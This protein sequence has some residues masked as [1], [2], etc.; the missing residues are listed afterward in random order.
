[1]AGIILNNFGGNL[2]KK[3]IRFGIYGFAAIILVCLYVEFRIYRF[4]WRSKPVK[5]DSI[6]VLGCRVRGTTP[7]R[8]LIA[9]LE[10][11]LR[12]YN[13]GYGKYII[14][15]G[16]QGPGEDISEAEAMRRYLVEEG[17][18]DSAI[19][20]EDEST[21][22]MENLINSKKKMDELGLKNAVVVSNKYHLKRASI[23]AERAKISASYSGV[24][25]EDYLSYEISGFIREIPAFIKFLVFD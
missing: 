2:M 18:K 16:G 5:S 24:F 10:E 14:V 23:M 3:V 6:I 15:S 22:T 21:S 1:M 11:G 13:E 17:V 12:L 9:R 20:M 4:G 7:S 19:I 8:F 25:V